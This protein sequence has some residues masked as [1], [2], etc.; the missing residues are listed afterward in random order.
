[1]SAWRGFGVSLCG[2]RLALLAGDIEALEFFG[3]YLLPWLP[4]TPPD[5][6]ADAVFR[7]VRHPEGGFDAHAG[8]QAMASRD[9]LPA[10]YEHV[11]YLVDEAMVKRLTH[12]AA[13]HAGV[14][15]WHGRA[16]LLPGPSGA[17]KTTL[18]AE[19]LQRGA[20]YYSDEY[21]LLDPEGR[22]EPYPRP[23]LLRHGSGNRRPALAAEWQAPTG[24]APAPLGWIVSV[25]RQEGAAW[26]VRSQ[27]QSEALLSL[28]RNTPHVMQDRP[29]LRDTLRR[30]AAS[31]ACFAGVRGEA[32]QA[33]SGILEI[34]SR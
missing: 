24:S 23:L 16:V 8:A 7:I 2:W 19:L 30:A 32:A 34:V 6:Q 20:E 17:G 12:A 4:R 11:Q 14:V 26:S 25:E 1:M 3:R 18:V 9:T 28:L 15:A 22:V 13:V 33:A 29:A 5:E 10:I 21:A 31:A 27:P